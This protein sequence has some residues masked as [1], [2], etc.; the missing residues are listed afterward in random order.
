MSK[1][2]VGQF[3]IKIGSSE[4]WSRLNRSALL[5]S[6]MDSNTN[7]QSTLRALGA[8]ASDAIEEIYEDLSKL[9]TQIRFLDSSDRNALAKQVEELYDICRMAGVFARHNSECVQGLNLSILSPW[10]S[11]FRDEW[12]IERA[13]SIINQFPYSGSEAVDLLQDAAKWSISSA[14]GYDPEKQAFLEAVEQ[15]KGSGFLLDVAEEYQHQANRPGYEGGCGHT[16]GSRSYLA[17]METKVFGTSVSGFGDPDYERVLKDA[18]RSIAEQLDQDLDNAIRENDYITDETASKLKAVVSELDHCGVNTGSLNGKIEKLAW[19]VGGDPFAIRRLQQ[20][21]NKLG[22]GLTEDGVF[23][24]KTLNALNDFHGELTRG[25]FPTLAWVDPLQSKT[26]G[27]EFHKIPSMRGTNT[28]DYASFLDLSSRSQ[29]IKGGKNRGIT[30]FRADQHKTGPYHINTVSGEQLGKGEYV[31]S[32]NLQRNIISKLNHK[33]I[34]ERTY[35]ILKDFDRHAKKI[36]IAGK[37]MAVTGAA[38]DVLEIA[39]TI[40]ID[41]HDADRKLGKTTYSTLASIGGSWSLGALGA[42]GGAMLGASIGTAILPGV[43]TA[44]GGAVGSLVLGIAGSYS[45]SK[46]GEYVIDITMTE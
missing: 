16:V 30:V 42:K 29:N 3:N 6:L 11:S 38:L 4:Y 45:G 20:A 18:L 35:R 22:Y 46:L 2:A 40:H 41:T 9:G 44:I 25:T 12:G 8:R 37:V 15:G 14:A 39:Q 7:Y 36:R 5:G 43:G 31:P 13:I 34:D 33:T 10:T 27:I 32:S 17:Y 21:L 19:F 26:T 24:T 23:G 1:E 28:V